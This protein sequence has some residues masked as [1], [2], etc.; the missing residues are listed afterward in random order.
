MLPAE[1]EERL[2]LFLIMA[3]ELPAAKQTIDNV[4]RLVCKYDV[5]KHTDRHFIFDCLIEYYKALEEFE[6]CAELLKYK[7]EKNRNKRITA[8]GLTRTDLADL[9][10]LGFQISDIVA[11][12]V[13]ASSGSCK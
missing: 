13:L 3:D 7:L 12:K 10:L 11:L 6:K 5:P 8:K 1:R 2:K 4:F 9:R